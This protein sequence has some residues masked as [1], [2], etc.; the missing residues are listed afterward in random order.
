MRVALVVFLAEGLDEALRAED[1][2]SHS[3]VSA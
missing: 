2:A 1:I 3:V